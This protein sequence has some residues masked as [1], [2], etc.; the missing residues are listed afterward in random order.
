MDMI[1]LSRK[2][3]YRFYLCL[4][5]IFFL[6]TSVDTVGT[7]YRTPFTE[8]SFCEKEKMSVKYKFIRYF[9]RLS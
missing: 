8:F 2:D 3:T 6:T 5:L 7:P 4:C 9:I 1:D